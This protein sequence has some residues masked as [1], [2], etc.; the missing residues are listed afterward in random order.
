MADGLPVIAAI[1]NYNMA[2]HLRRLLPQALA[3]DYDAV[4]VL[5]DASTDN[6]V[7]VVNEF[8][9]DVSLIRRRENRGA[10][11]N[12]N[13]I[14]DHVGDG[15]LIHFIDADMDLATPETAAVAREVVARY[16]DQGVGV[17]GGLVSRP[18]GTQEPHNYG[19]VLSLWGSLTSGLP[20]FVDRV[21]D[22]PRVARIVQTMVAPMM[23]E[24]PNVRADPAPA[25]AYW[26][27]EGNM[28]IYSS[29][30][31]SIGGY[32]P[33]L[34]GHETQ[35][36]ALR[37]EKKGIKRQFD[38]SVKVIHHAVDVRGQKPWPM[39]EQGLYPPDA[40]ARS[41][42]LADRPLAA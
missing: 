16:A 10:G 30:F 1:P 27:L 21:R 32:D 11:A 42:P 34:R 8:G 25:P 31:R 36:L 6:S 15:A 20:V 7:D 39:G 9:T 26:V 22:K 13:Q 17:V 14:I 18:D 3:Q 24:W 29:L 35:D 33:A 12:R 41:V 19:A 40:Q 38:P 23:T 37:L 28:L 2:D 5:D 4:F